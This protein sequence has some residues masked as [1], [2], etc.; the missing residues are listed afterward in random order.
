MA[1]GA[2]DGRQS[3]LFRA[4]L[5]QIADMG[6]PPAKL[7]QATDWGLL[8]KAFG[9]VFPTSRATR[10]RRGS[11]RDFRSSNTCAISRTRAYARLGLRTMFETTRILVSLF[12]GALR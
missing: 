6:H 9:A 12:W 2:G 4:R 1:K 8:E 11:W 7:A 10:R 5:D 3:D